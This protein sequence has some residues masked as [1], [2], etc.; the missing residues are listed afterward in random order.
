LVNF[1]HYRFRYQDKKVP[2]IGPQVSVILPCYEGKRWL[3]K[4]IESVIAQTGVSWELVIVDDGSSVSPEGIV[5]SFQ[6]ERIRYFRLPHA[7]KGI[8]LNRGAA[9]SRAG[10][11]CFLDQDD[12]ML[13]GRLCLQVAAFH[14]E[15]ATE[16]VYSDYE[17]VT[18]RGEWLDRFISRQAGCEE[19]LRR[20]ARGT[21]LVSMQTLMLR[22]DVYDKIG[23]FSEDPDL[24][25]AD[26]GEFFTRLFVC[27]VRLRYQPGVVQQWVRHERNYSSSARFQEARLVFLKHLAAMAEEHPGLQGVLPLFRHNT[28]YMRGLYYLEHA[29]PGKACPEFIRAIGCSPANWNAYYLLAKAWLKACTVK[30]ST[31]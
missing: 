5:R 9:E 4:A 14:A 26:D 27:G 12:I 1:L 17:R 3:R 20:M 10:L 7:G 28:Y 11:L 13:P 31:G 2:V 21:A 16:V 30:V 8:A 23:G 22:K 25:G 15:P 29:M 6:D 18:D 19:C 24:T